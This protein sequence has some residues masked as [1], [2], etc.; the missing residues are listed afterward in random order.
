MKQVSIRELAGRSTQ[1]P[2]G[3]T[4]ATIASSSML[5]VVE[6][7]G[8]RLGIGGVA[9]LSAASTVSAVSRGKMTDGGSAY[10]PIRE[11]RDGFPSVIQVADSVELCLWQACEQPVPCQRRAPWVETARVPFA[12]VPTLPFTTPG[13][14]TGRGVFRIGCP[15]RAT[16]T[17]WIG[18]PHISG[19][20]RSVSALVRR[21]AQ[22]VG[23]SPEA[24]MIG[25]S[26]MQETVTTV[27][28]VLSPLGEESTAAPIVVALQGA[29][30]IELVLAGRDPLTTDSS[31]YCVIEL[32]DP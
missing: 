6:I 2:A 7:D 13:A 11:T 17:I 18:V 3:F 16:A 29:T 19:G 9:S 26:P 20:G 22:V 10:P 25:H 30:E 31:Y 21:R 1:L 24:D 14:S 8:T 28:H 12:E 4:Y 32:V 5:D 15:G 23:V 27:T